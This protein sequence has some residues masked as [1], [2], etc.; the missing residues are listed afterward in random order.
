ML[1][2]H[3]LFRRAHTA[4][5]TTAVA[6]RHWEYRLGRSCALFTGGDGRWARGLSKSWCFVDEPR[7]TAN[8]LASLPSALAN[9][10]EPGIARPLT[11]ARLVVWGARGDQGLPQGSLR[12]L[13]SRTLA[14]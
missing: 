10:L 5:W 12:S 11:S 1:A 9:F 13:A 7:A 3:G 4:F 14:P 6:G 8:R 2:D